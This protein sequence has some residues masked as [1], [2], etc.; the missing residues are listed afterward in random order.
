MLKS[1]IEF[2]N[3]KPM[4]IIDGTP[5]FPLAYTAYFDECGE[6]ADFAK[7]GYRMFFVNVSFTDLPINNFTGFTPFR[8]GVF[9]GEIPDYTEF[10]K[11]VRRIVSLCSDALIFPRINI[12]MPR[13]WIEENPDQ[14]VITPKGGARESLYSEKFRQDGAQLLK[15]LVTHIRESDYADRIAGYHLCGGITQE[16][17]HHDL[18]GSFSDMG[19]RKFAQWVR[20]KYGIE[21]IKTPERS[22]F[23]GGK[24]SEDYRIFSEFCSEEVTKT[25]EHFA[26]SL[27]ELINSEQIVGVFYGYNSFVNDPLFGLHGL[28][29]II[30][31]PYIDFFSSPCCYDGNRHLGIDWGDMVPPDSL[32]LHGKLYFVECDIRTHLTR[33]MQL[34]RPGE[35]PEDIYAT[36]DENGNKT[37]WSGPDTLALSL[38]AIR[39][40]FAHQLTKFSGIWWFDMWGGWYHSEKIMAELS[41]L[42]RVYEDLHGIDTSDLPRAETALFVDERAYANFARETYLRDTVNSI[43]VALGNSGIPFDMYMTEDAEKV[44][45]NYRAAIFTAPIPSQSG[46]ATVE[47]C[48][49]LGTPFISSSEEKPFFT[50]EELRDFLVNAGVHC[51]NT[52]GCV[53]YCAGGLLG[54]HTV[55]DGETK[56]TLPEK[57]KVTPLTDGTGKESETQV[58]TFTAKE[59]ET[60]LFK[61]DK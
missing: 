13:K 19:V 36:V 41:H 3:G 23:C 12:A 44:L 59:H 60:F 15:T 39:K 38:S 8:T 25:V 27:K 26:K 32:K 9:E 37:V 58:I 56:I 7:S 30:N 55:C 1:K 61:L 16:W 24:F 43:R 28:R 6:W 52:D 45:K 49:K 2:T 17:M 51:Y 54:V 29:H 50:T 40:A 53:V 31:S 22:D 21:E 33:R 10:D 34:S 46:R 4:I 20:E 5:H 11:N 57:L 42:R 48:K 18:Y 14:T 47:L 35:Y